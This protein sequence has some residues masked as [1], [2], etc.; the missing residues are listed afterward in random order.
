MIRNDP[1]A[2]TA[3]GHEHVPLSWPP[4]AR[5][6]STARSG[7][8]LTL[9]QLRGEVSRASACPMVGNQASGGYSRTRQMS[10]TCDDAGHG[11][12]R[13]AVYFL[14]AFIASRRKVP[15]LGSVVVVNV[16]LG[17]TLIGWVV[18]LAM[19]CRDPRPHTAAIPPWMPPTGKHSG[20]AG[21]ELPLPPCYG[22]GA[23]AVM[24][25]DGR[26]PATP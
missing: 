24:H 3:L 22:C 7:L 1:T 6:A 2:G 5:H 15:H 16:F 12:P 23:P 8:R 14:P 17:W 18:A 13:V 20:P 9:D 25:V 19:A 10:P 26:C 4:T 11:L 21:P